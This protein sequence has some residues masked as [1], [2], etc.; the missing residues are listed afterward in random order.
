MGINEDGYDLGPYPM[1]NTNS[2]LLPSSPLDD[3]Y[4]SPAP[5]PEITS[6]CKCTGK[7]KIFDFYFTP[8]FIR[9]NLWFF[10]DNVHACVRDIE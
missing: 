8:Y 9:K 7:I 6:D 10:S 4:A 5:Q 2:S 3:M 1:R